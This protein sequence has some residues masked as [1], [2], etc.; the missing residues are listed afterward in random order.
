MIL[1]ILSAVFTFT[2]LLFCTP[3]IRAQFTE[4]VDSSQ[5]QVLPSPG[6]SGRY[7]VHD[8]PS[9]WLKWSEFGVKAFSLRIGFALIVD[10]A[11]NGQD[12]ESRE[13]VGNQESKIDLRS[14]E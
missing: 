7:F 3:G 13:Q 5:S 2:I 9:K 4:P 8:I 14:G 6:K 10:Y 11:W 12:N 1:L